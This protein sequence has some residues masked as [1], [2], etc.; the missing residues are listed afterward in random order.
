[1]KAIIEKLKK[2]WILIWLIIAAFAT[3]AF[4]VFADYTGVNSVKRVVTT[5][6]T[7]I[8]EM[9]SSNALKSSYSSQRISA[10]AYTVTVCNYDQ[11]SITGANPID[12][13]YNITADLCILVGEDFVRVSE[14]TND[15]ILEYTS[16]EQE[17]INALLSVLEDRTY[18][19]NNVALN[20][21]RTCTQYVLNGNTLPHDVRTT[22]SYKV[23]FDIT[24][25]VD[26]E[27]DFYVFIE[28]TPTAGVEG[29]KIGNRLCAAKSE[30][31][32]A[33]W[34]GE[35]KEKDCSSVDYDFYNYIISGSGA[36]TIDIMWD[37][38]KFEINEFFLS[39]LSGNEFVETDGEIITPDTTHSGSWNKIVLKVDST[40]TDKKR[41]ELQLYKVNGALSYIGDNS[42]S[43]YI[44]YH[45]TESSGS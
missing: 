30:A 12:I 42:A 5:Q 38:T 45:Y 15:K 27:P 13:I 10:T 19:F 24:E 14:L 35:L 44:D 26:S 16:A 43:K 9:F 11:D 2:R 23:E 29:N 36:G 1:M 3:G 25:V 40:D 34:K 21:G 20:S 28:V 33:S 8:G 37:T 17:K 18:K 4:V 39:D 22:H 41:F 32:R 31:D 6:S 7:E